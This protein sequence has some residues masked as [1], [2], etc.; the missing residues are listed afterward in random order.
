MFSAQAGLF[1]GN[2]AVIPSVLCE[3]TDSSN[4]AL[5]FPIFGLFWPIGAIVGY[6]SP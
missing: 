4:Q 5:A 2:V 6:V 1:S 3:I